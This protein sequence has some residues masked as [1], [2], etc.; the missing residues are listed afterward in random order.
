MKIKVDYQAHLEIRRFSN[1]LFGVT[2][3]MILQACKE[4]SNN[5][6]VKVRHVHLW[7]NEYFK[8]QLK[9]HPVI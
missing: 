9:D 6:A 8:K 1:V 2:E 5:G 4:S 3:D 7:Y